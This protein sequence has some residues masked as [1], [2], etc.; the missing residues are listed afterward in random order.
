MTDDLFDPAVN[1]LS[2]PAANTRGAMHANA[3]PTEREAALRVMPKT[4]TQRMAVLDAI[5]TAGDYGLTDPEIAEATGFYLYSA[6][7]RRNELL[8]GG[9]V[10]DSG[11]RRGTGRGGSA[12]AWR[13]TERAQIAL[14]AK[15]EG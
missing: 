15:G 5:A 11:I 6:A 13:I 4:G 14:A 10:E 7:P 2:D 9:W 1:V 8:R 12:I 3:Q